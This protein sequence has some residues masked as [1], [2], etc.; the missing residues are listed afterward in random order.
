LNLD[1]SHRKQAM[2][3][4]SYLLARLEALEKEK[5]EIVNLLATHNWTDSIKTTSS[6]M[7]S[8]SPDKSPASVKSSSSAK[9]SS[10]V[11]SPPGTKYDKKA[12]EKAKEKKWLCEIC[13]VDCPAMRRKQHENTVKHIKNAAEKTVVE[14]AS[15]EKKESTPALSDDANRCCARTRRDEDHFD[16]DGKLKMMRDDP[17]NLYGG[18][19][20][21]TKLADDFCSQHISTQ[22]CGIWGGVYG[23]KFNGDFKRLAKVSCAVSASSTNKL[24]EVEVEYAWVE[25]DSEDYMI[26]P[27]GNVYDPESEKKVGHYNIK[28]KKWISGGP[29]LST[30]VFQNHMSIA[31]PVLV[32]PKDGTIHD[33][34]REDTNGQYNIVVKKRVA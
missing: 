5:Q 24:Q 3:T 18:R 4:L 26:D 23:A 12:Y 31:K 22:P 14:C 32:H 13:Q 10:P 20:S 34:C 9:S 11:K 19:C 6:S 28:T 17:K 29:T 16:D 30:S 15:R 33:V 7:P 8:S 25:I 27:E 21:R 1:T 2:S